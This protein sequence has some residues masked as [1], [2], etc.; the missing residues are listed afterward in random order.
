MFFLVE[1]D[2]Y[3]QS[4]RVRTT[5]TAEVLEKN[6]IEHRSIKLESATKLEQAFEMLVFGAYTSF[7]LSML[8]GIDPAP[9]PWV[10]WFKDQLKQRA[11][12]A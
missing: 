6:K 10:D 11:Y 2:L 9:I 3:L 7:Y 8:H 12:A 5:L 1:S 4:N